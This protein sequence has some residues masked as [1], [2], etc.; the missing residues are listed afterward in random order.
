[1]AEQRRAHE[2]EVYMPEE[3]SEKQARGRLNV[4]L[5]S[6]QARNVRVEA[7]IVDAV[8]AIG[9]EPAASSSVAAA[10]PVSG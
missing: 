2:L 8:P 4:C 9:H 3:R 5:A 7:Y 1:V 6:W 10:A